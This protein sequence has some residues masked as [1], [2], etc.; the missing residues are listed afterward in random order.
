MDYEHPSGQIMD[1]DWQNFTALLHL[2]FMQRALLGGVMLGTTGGLLGSI[3]VL[4]Q[5]SFFGDA[6]G[7]SALLGISLGVLLGISPNVILIP[8]L[9]C[10]G[11]GV[12]YLL[13]KTQLWNDALLNIVY[14]AAL[15]MSVII[16]SF[17]EQYQ[18]GINQ[19]LFGDILAI[20][21]A[22]LWWNGALLV[23]C[24]G[25]LGL[26]L[27]TQ[28]L[29]SLDESLAKV[30]GVAV[31]QHRLAFVVLLSL[32]VAVAIKSVGVLLVS[33]FIVIPACTAR[34][35]SQRFSLYVVLSALL[36][37]SCALVGVLLSA[38]LDLP[39]GPTIVVTQFGAFL[40]AIALPTRQAFTA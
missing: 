24:T 9:I 2:P 22:N 10:F 26:T 3:T 20:S 18:G 14:S 27:R 28:M 39:S 29:L 16:L 15:A 13:E 37:G 36:G 12:M 5:L 6:L 34:L 33:A 7:H 32:V 40:G 25:F 17:V 8:F 11:L 1:L 23:G 19:L 35:L 31:Y 38:L 30:R 21:P 4:R